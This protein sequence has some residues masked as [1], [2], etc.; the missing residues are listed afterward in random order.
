MS[1]DTNPID[2]INEKLDNVPF[3]E[4]QLTIKKHHNRVSTVDFHQ[5]E[6]EKFPSNQEAVSHLLQLLKEMQDATQS[7]SLTFTV[8]FDKG[9]ITRIV[10]QGYQRSNY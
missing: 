7:G 8:V 3:G 2:D 9:D 5:Y 6:S 1:K 10:R 4:I